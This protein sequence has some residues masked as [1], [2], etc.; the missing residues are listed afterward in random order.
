MNKIEENL[1]EWERL[2][3]KIKQDLE[4]VRSTIPWL[5]EAK[6]EVDLRC[7]YILFGFE[8][9]VQKQN[10]DKLVLNEVQTIQ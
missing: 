4:K 2:V 10:R 8:S 7:D 9:W 1:Q 6:E 5:E 3:K